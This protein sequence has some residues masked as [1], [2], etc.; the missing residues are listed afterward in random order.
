M[1]PKQRREGME[2]ERVK[3]NFAAKPA[4]ESGEIEER[5]RERMGDNE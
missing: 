4:R 1:Q 2:S 5:E 3:K